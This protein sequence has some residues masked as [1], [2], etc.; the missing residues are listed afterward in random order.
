MNKGEHIFIGIIAFLIYIGIFSLLMKNVTVG[1]FL[2]IVCVIIGSILPD[3]LEPADN[4]MHRGICHSKRT[5]KFSAKLFGVTAII[6]L[7]SIVLF[8][9][10]LIF[11]LSCFVLGYLVHLLAD[12]T[13]E[14]GLPD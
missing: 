13:T 6:T 14:V 12:S 3:I 11:Y 7:I 2:G 10:F 8:R 1:F 5:L 9:D 4:W